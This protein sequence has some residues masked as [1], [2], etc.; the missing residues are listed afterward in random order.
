MIS[1]VLSVIP[2][3]RVGT[4]DGRRC[5]HIVLATKISSVISKSRWCA[6]NTI[7]TTSF[8]LPLWLS[9][10]ELWKVF[11]DLRLV[12]LICSTTDTIWF[13]IWTIALGNQ[14]SSRDI[15]VDQFVV[16]WSCKTERWFPCLNG[17]KGLSMLL[18]RMYMFRS[19]LLFF[20]CA[21]VSIVCVLRRDVYQHYGGTAE[22]CG[23]H[24]QCKTVHILFWRF[25]SSCS[26]CSCKMIVVK[27][28]G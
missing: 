8:F 7:V 12:V 21:R 22:F 5:G 16:C 14:I 24:F 11:Q 25:P 6:G 27:R 2:P 15:T 3:S 23:P 18:H 10:R 17:T 20:R 19:N 28:F 1:R 26:W 13:V 9:M 4:V